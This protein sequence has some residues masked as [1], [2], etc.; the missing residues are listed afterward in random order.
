MRETYVTEDGSVNNQLLKDKNKIKFTLIILG[1]IVF[2]I[3]VF[4]IIRMIIRNNNCNKIY[5]KINEAALEYAEDN[6][7]LPH[8]EGQHINV[9]LDDLLDQNLITDTDITIDEKKATAKIKITKYEEDYFVTTELFDCSYCDTT[10]DKWSKE[11]NKKPNKNSVDIIAYYNYKEKEI[12]KTPFTRWYS[13]EQLNQKED[14][15]YKMKLPEELPEVPKSGKTVDIEREQITYYSYRDKKCKYYKVE[16]DYTNYFSSEQPAGYANKDERTLKYTT[17]TKYSLNYPDE[18]DYRSIEQ[19]NG[20]KFYYLDGRKKI[21]FNNGEYTV[22]EDLPDDKEYRKDK[23]ANYAKMYSYKDKQWK[24]YNGKQRVYSSLTTTMP[25][26]YIYLDTDFCEYT[27]WTN[28]KEASYLSD[29]NKSY[30]EERTIPMYKYRMVY[31]IYSL[32][33]LDK[34]L[35]IKDFEKKMN[36]NIEDL[37]KRQDIEIVVDYKFKIKK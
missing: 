11:L 30:R 6:D 8:S 3:V 4:F 15:T 23:N 20:Y 25:K 35:N 31:E 36:S 27:K 29:K 28:Y 24:W 14:K 9:K 2:I 34:Y 18:K 33:V 32:E 16:S 10:N 19:K 7:I 17:P 22:E 26:N 37:F 21:Y 5:D 13:E 1:T 12:N